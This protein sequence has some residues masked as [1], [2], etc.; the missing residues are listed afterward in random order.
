[1]SAARGNAHCMDLLR[2]AG[3]P[4]M[5]VDGAPFLG[6]AGHIE[7]RAALSFEMGGHP[8]KRTNRH[9]AGSTD[10]GNKNTVGLVE[11]RASR[12]GQR[13]QLVLAKITALPLPQRT[14]VHRD[15]ARTETFDAGIILVAAR[16][17]DF[18]FAAELGLDGN[19]RQAVR[20]L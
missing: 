11:I 13:R 1:M 17:I 19:Y 14:A 4:H 16:L 10:A 2:P 12:L 6:E 18:A 3:D 7:D 20:L 8:E 5:T 9:D 15:E